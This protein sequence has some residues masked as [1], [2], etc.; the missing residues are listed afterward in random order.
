MLIMLMIILIIYS[1][2][3]R[4][5]AQPQV[6]IFFQRVKHPKVIKGTHLSNTTCLMQ[7][8]FKSDESC[9]RFNQPHQTSNA[10]ENKRG[11]IRQVALNKQCHPIHGKSDI[12]IYIYIYICTYTYTHTC[13]CMY[14]Y[15]YINIYIYTYIYI[16]VYIYVYTYIQ[17][18][19]YIYT[20][21]HTHI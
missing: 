20:Y 18:Y 14:I 16:Y 10:V 12:Y 8:F 4:F 15:I 19:I 17:T 13:V 9:I 7:L 2:I 21:I 1:Q 6:R 3:H 11:R 5:L